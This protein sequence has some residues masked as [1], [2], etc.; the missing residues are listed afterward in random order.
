MPYADELSKSQSFENDVISKAQKMTSDAD[1]Y[2]YIAGLADDNKLTW[3]QAETILKRLGI[4]ANPYRQA[5]SLI[6]E[7][8]KAPVTF[9]K[10]APSKLW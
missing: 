5:Q 2:D 4:T 3:V 8:N 1:K 9:L 10:K 7:I 6:D